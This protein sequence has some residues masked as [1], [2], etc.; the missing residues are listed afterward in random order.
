MRASVMRTRPL[1]RGLPADLWRQTLSQV[2]TIFGRLVYLASL[3][4][5][6]TGRYEHHGLA[7]IHGETESDTA[8]RESHERTFQEWLNFGIE[9]QKADLDLYLSAFSNDKVNLVETWIRLAPYRNM[10]PTSVRPQERELYLAD[11]ESLLWM[12]KNECRADGP[13]PGS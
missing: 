11:L 12:L 8:L 4:N 7:L 5:S 6:N 3:R 10:V 13:V 2:P 9:Q 1:Q